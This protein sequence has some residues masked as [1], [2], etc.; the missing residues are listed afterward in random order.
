MSGLNG[1]MEIY[2]GSEDWELAMAEPRIRA[3][4]PVLG[5]DGVHSDDPLRYPSP[6]YPRDLSLG[7]LMSLHPRNAVYLDDDACSV[8]SNAAFD[9]IRALYD[10]PAE[11]A[12]D[13][14]R[15]LYDPPAEPP[16]SR[17]STASSLLPPSPPPPSPARPSRRKRLTSLF[18]RLVALTAST[19]PPAAPREMH[20]AYLQRDDPPIALDLRKPA[21]S[22]TSST[23]TFYTCASRSH[24]PPPPVPP[25]ARYAP[26]I[27]YP[28]TQPDPDLGDLTCHTPPAS[29]APSLEPEPR[30]ARIK[31]RLRQQQSMATLNSASTSS[32]D[33]DPGSPS[34][35]YSHSSFSL[36][37]PL[38]PV[39]FP[40]FPD[41]P[42]PP[43]PPP[44]RP[45][46][47]TALKALSIP[48]LPAFPFRPRDRSRTT[49]LLPSPVL[50][51]PAPAPPPPPTR[52][53]KRLTIRLS[54]AARP[55]DVVLPPSPRG[56][57]P[58]PPKD[59][60]DDYEYRRATGAGLDPRGRVVSAQWSALW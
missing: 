31:R 60:T 42:P 4:S 3:D 27:D 43:P 16:S 18:T 7:C 11:P 20:K 44:Q 52:N 50:A 6:N 19:P 56:P 25:K 33:T 41:N 10:P 32:Y 38:S 47:T 23:S 8:A 36:S 21:H 29:P 14:I 17:W 15:A 1:D 12:F 28:D 34:W 53:A 57:P 55:V 5:F 54:G 9:H 49:S 59:R 30:R 46:R 22:P 37:P 2:K 58:V 26:H 24:T 45:R 51:A 40:S 39:A 35:S 48:I 13:H